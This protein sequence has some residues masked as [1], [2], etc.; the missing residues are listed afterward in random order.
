MQETWV[1]SLGQEDPLQK[2]KATHSSILAWRIPWTICPWGHKESDA[3][4]RL[5]L[6]YI[7]KSESAS[8]LDKD[9]SLR[10]H[11]LQSASLLCPW[12]FP[13][14]NTGVGSH[15]LLQ[16]IFPT[17]G[18]N[19]GLPHCR[20][21]LYQLNHKGSPHIYIYIY[22]YMYIYV[23]MC[24]YIHIYTHTHTHSYMHIYT[25]TYICINV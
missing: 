7:Y 13:G 12:D 6:S 25:H 15:S 10:P 23:Y 19:P 17:Q 9:N 20:Q 21:I 8:G 2:G 22:M 1:Q 3:T 16:G 5:S 18:L 11:G 14:K 4:E 24:I